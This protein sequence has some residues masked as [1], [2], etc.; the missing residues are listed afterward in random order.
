MYRPQKVR[1][2]NLTIGGRY[3]MAKYSYEFKKKV[4]MAYLNGEGGTP[5][6]CE[7]Y[8]IADTKNL[9]VWISIYKKFGDEGLVFYTY[10]FFRNTINNSSTERCII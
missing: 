7:K 4:V 10:D 5:Y 1:P 3:F 8:G 9:R 6:L 2:K